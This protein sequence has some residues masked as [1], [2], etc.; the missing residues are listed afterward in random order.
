MNALPP[1]CVRWITRNGEDND[2]GIAAISLATGHSYEQVLG[3]AV[4]LNPSVLMS[5]MSN[6]EIRATLTEL[7]YDS[8]VRRKFDLEEDTG[9]LIIEDHRQERHAVYLW[10]GRIIE[11]SL[12][13]RSLW[14]DANNYLLSEKSKAVWLI[15]PKL[16]KE[17]GE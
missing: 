10:E 16:H 5:G 2:C 3:V 6:K 12:G 8:K 14:L 9:V 1:D 11:P 4:G 13:R 15:E 17:E 7:G